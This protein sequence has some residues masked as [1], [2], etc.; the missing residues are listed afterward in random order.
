MTGGLVQSRSGT[1]LRL[2][3]FDGPSAAISSPAADCSGDCL[4][5]L[6]EQGARR[7]AQRTSSI[8]LVAYLLDREPQAC[9]DAI[10]YSLRTR[11]ADDDAA[12]YNSRGVLLG[13]QGKPEEA[14]RKLAQALALA[15][16]E[17]AGRRF[18]ASIEN[19]WGLVLARQKD[20]AGARR[21]YAAAVAADSSFARASWRRRRGRPKRR[22]RSTKQA[23]GRN[24]KLT[25]SYVHQAEALAQLHRGGEALDRLEEAEEPA[26]RERALEVPPGAPT[27]P[28]PGERAGKM[29]RKTSAAHAGP[30]PVPPQGLPPPGAPGAGR[31]SG[32]DGR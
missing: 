27:A 26:E 3:I 28:R 23:I 22:W 13:R 4:D 11:P 10:W 29:M 8:A 12:A 20:F 25:R 18:E 6:L 9:A 1:T 16:K 2:A 7:A 21:H 32:V 24:P 19:G 31:L 17:D 5:G 15:K 14:Q 30:L